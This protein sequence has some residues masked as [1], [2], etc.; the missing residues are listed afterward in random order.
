MLLLQ[1]NVVNK[2]NPSNK[3]ATDNI[4]NNENVFSL[5]N[6]LVTI[7]EILEATK[8]LQDKKNPDHNGI[9]SNFIKKIIFN[10][11]HPLHH[12]FRLSF[13]HGM[14][15]TQL[16]I[17]KVVPIFKSGDRCNMD[18]YWPISLL[19]CFSKILEK[20]VS[21]RLSSFLATCNILSDW[22][23]GFRAH[24]STIHPMIHLTNFLTNSINEKKHSLAIFC[25]LRKAFDCCDHS[26][27][28]AKLHK[29]GIGGAELSWFE[30]YL[31]D[32]KQFVTV[33]GKNSKLINV[34]LGV[35]QGSIL[36]PLLFL[37]YI[38]DLPLAS[39]L[40]TLLFADDTTLLASAD[41]VES[42]NLFVNTE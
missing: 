2:I 37:L 6:S 12:I 8:A 21:L 16:K 14:V 38:N 41:S 30:S 27:L 11:A 1:L 22:Q 17:A 26:I 10:I 36:G 29:Y 32:R 3:S 33:N 39:N 18:N 42:L 23:F 24:H 34:L 5:N 9:S 19:S 25:D 40:F 7:S 35:P 20:I 31:S 4:P 13:E 28:L 15:P